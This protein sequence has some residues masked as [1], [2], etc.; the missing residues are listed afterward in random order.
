MWHAYVQ[1]LF[2]ALALA[3]LGFGIGKAAVLLGERAIERRL[4]T[5]SLRDLLARRA[6]M[7]AGFEAR[8]T[9]R[10]ADLRKAEGESGEAL[11]RRQ[12]LERRLRDLQNRGDDL[13]RLIGEEVAGTP[14]YI[15]QVVNKYVGD[16]TN[17]PAQHA[18]IDSGWARPQTV[19]VWAR[20]MP[21]ARAEIER[22]YPPAFGYVVLRIQEAP[23]ASPVAAN[24]A[25]MTG[26]AE[27]GHG[28]SARDAA[29]PLAKA[30]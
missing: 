26:G 21:V 25:I 2:L 15:A 5:G 28:D 12:S 14:C 19:E 24:A 22:R 16:G 9:Q 11:R 29:L 20:T 3:G 18:F 17:Q 6:K 7:E 13:L 1:A 4:G 10:I 8:R 27:A 23:Q 30:S